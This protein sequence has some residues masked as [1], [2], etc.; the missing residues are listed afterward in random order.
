MLRKILKSISNIKRRKKEKEEDDVI[1][2]DKMCR[3]KSSPFI[4]YIDDSIIGVSSLTSIKL[5]FNEYTLIPFPDFY[6]GIDATS[7]VT[8]SDFFTTLVHDNHLNASIDRNAKLIFIGNTHKQQPVD[9]PSDI[10]LVMFVKNQFDD[11]LTYDGMS[12]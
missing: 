5:K 8:M 4:S 3:V 2:T 12:N 9:I 1:R 11:L 6:D 7:D 10:V